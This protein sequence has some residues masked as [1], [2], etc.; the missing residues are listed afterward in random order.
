[1]IDDWKL[2]IYGSNDTRWPVPLTNYPPM[3]MTKFV[4]YNDYG[5]TSGWIS[6][7]LFNITAD[8]LEKYDL[9]FAEPAVVERLNVTFQRLV[10]IMAPGLSCAAQ[11][12]P[13]ADSAVK[14]WRAHNDTIGPYINDPLYMYE[15]SVDYCSMVPSAAPS[16]SPVPSQPNPTWSPTVYAPTVHP[17]PHP[18]PAPTAH[19]RAHPV[20]APTTHESPHPVPAPTVDESP[21]PVPAPTAHESSH[22]VPAPTAHERAHPVPAPT[23]RVR[24]P[25]D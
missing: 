11:V 1:M 20:P 21:H 18:A 23:A 13:G 19:E 5:G 4:S 16:A 25:A 3:G 9:K 10:S 22:P 8:P 6:A 12:G 14:T 2:V 24:A 17:S 15:C 7:Q